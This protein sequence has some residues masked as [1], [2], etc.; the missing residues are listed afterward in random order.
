MGVPAVVPSAARVSI[1]ETITEDLDVCEESENVVD[2]PVVVPSAA[3]V[4]ISEE[5]S[6]DVDVCEESENVMDI[7]VP[8]SS[9]ELVS[10]SE[11]TSMDVDACEKSEIEVDVSVV[12]DFDSLQTNPGKD[13]VPSEPINSLADI[14][15][16]V[17]MR[18]PEVGLEDHVIQVRVGSESGTNVGDLEGKAI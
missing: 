4:S 9:A 8:V 14:E 13:D 5:T 7:P 3:L 16:G 1:S 6:M 18:S 2:I 12:A 11:E 15:P 17:V 10:V